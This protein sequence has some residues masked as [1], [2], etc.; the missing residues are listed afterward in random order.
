MPLR[1]S[2][3]GCMHAEADCLAGGTS[4]CV[5]FGR[6]RRARER[7]PR[8]RAMEQGQRMTGWSSTARTQAARQHGYPVPGGRESEP[9]TR[10]RAPDRLSTIA[11]PPRSAPSFR[12]AAASTASATDNASCST[13]RRCSAKPAIECRVEP[14]E[15]IE[16]RGLKHLQPSR[17]GHGSLRRA[18]QTSTQRPLST[19]PG[20]CGRFAA[21]RRRPGPAHAAV[22]APTAATIPWPVPAPAGSRAARSV[23]CAAPALVL[24]VPAPPARLWSC[25]IAAECSARRVLG[26]HLAEQRTGATAG[27]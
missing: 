2:A 22:R 3:R 26:L 11:R 12:S 27:R 25:A 9:A 8:S 23:C 5:P 15:I 16:Q 24:P 18:T 7:V 17:I 13:R 20:D 1:S 4:V 6:R 10:L 19:R 14:I 21:R